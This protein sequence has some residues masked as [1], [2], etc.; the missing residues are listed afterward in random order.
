MLLSCLCPAA[1]LRS[2][3]SIVES[4]IE[5][6]D[7]SESTASRIVTNAAETVIKAASRHHLHAGLRMPTETERQDGSG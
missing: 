4:H 2:R 1:P 7:R 6:R 5:T 3:A